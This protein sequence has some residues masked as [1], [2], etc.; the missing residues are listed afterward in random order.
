MEVEGMLEGNKKTKSQMEQAY[1]SIFDAVLNDVD[2]F[3]YIESSGFKEGSSS[4][5]KEEVVR[6][7]TPLYISQIELKDYRTYMHKTE[8]QFSPEEDFNQYPRTIEAD[9]DALKALKVFKALKPY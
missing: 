9:L 6:L 1:H 4:A 7:Q 3:N 8:L 5:P 2:I